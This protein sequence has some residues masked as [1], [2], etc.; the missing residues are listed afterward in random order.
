VIQVALGDYHTAALTSRGEMWTWGEGT[1]GQLGLGGPLGTVDRK[2]RFPG[3]EVERPAA[4]GLGEDWAQRRGAQMSENRGDRDSSLWVPEPGAGA[5]GADSGLE[6][7]T[8]KEYEKESE[9]HHVAKANNTFVFSIAAAGWHT[10][11]LVLGDPSAKSKT[12]SQSQSSEQVASTEQTSDTA[13]STAP[14]R[15]PQSSTNTNESRDQPVGGQMPGAFPFGSGGGGGGGSLAGPI[16]RVGFAGRGSTIGNVAQRNWQARAARGGGTNPQQ[17]AVQGELP[18]E[19]TGAN[20]DDAFEGGGGTAET[21]T[22]QDVVSR[23]QQP[24]FE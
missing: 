9:R 1:H 12:Q 7:K 15:P 10:G 11:A 23:W 19:A 3:D 13:G 17:H 22:E 14:S 16:F 24:G 4:E 5:P 20:E 6:G 8:E 2:V 18:M 21:E